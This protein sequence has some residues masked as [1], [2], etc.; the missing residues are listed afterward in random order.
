MMTAIFSINMS[1]Q[2]YA[3]HHELTPR[4]TSGGTTELA[5]DYQETFD[6]ISRNIA[7]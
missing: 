7:P 6:F 1:N 3:D 4:L 2:Q 5:H